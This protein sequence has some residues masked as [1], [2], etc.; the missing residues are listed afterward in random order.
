VESYTI[1]NRLVLHIA[2]IALSLIVLLLGARR[3]TAVSG[4]RAIPDT[5]N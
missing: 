3:E 4:E 2:P 5:P 1:V